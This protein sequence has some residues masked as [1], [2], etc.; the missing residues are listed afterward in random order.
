VIFTRQSTVIA[1]CFS[2]GLR[3]K[4]KTGEDVILLR[5]NGA[6]HEHFNA[7]ERERS[8]G[9]FTF[10][11]RQSAMLRL[12][13][14]SIRL[15][16]SSTRTARWTGLASP[17]RA[18]EYRRPEHWPRPTRSV[19][20]DMNTEELSGL[21]GKT[22]CASAEVAE[23]EPG[24]WRVHTPL[25]FPDGDG[26]SLYVRQLPSGGVRVSDLGATLMHMSY[27]NELLKFRNGTRGQLL[28]QILADASVQEDDSEFYVEAPLEELGRSV[29]RLGQG[30]TRIHDLSFLN[31]VRNENTFYED[32]RQALHGLLGAERVHEHYVVPGVPRPPEYPVDYYIEGGALPLYLF[33]VPN[34]DKA[35]LATIV[36]QHLIASDQ[37]FNSMV[38]FHNMGELPRPDVSRL[39]NAA[40]DQVDSLDAAADLKRKLLQRVK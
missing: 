12:G 22:F 37:Q 35:R 26:Y 1:S 10:T 34:R 11:G 28:D 15:R 6:D 14:K 5:C 30:L 38:V 16:P 36:L 7:I 9:T 32:L 33:G 17:D 31:R 29:F 21:L 24:L 2:A 3:W 19:R 27:D 39:T 20:A 8:V 4:S 13:G 25:V 40:N 18:G 23:V